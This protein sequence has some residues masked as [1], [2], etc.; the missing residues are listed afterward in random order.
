MAQQ[1]DRPQRGPAESNWAHLLICP[2]TDKYA[3][4]SASACRYTRCCLAIL[5]IRYFVWILLCQGLLYIVYTGNNGCSRYLQHRLACNRHVCQQ[6]CINMQIHR[7]Q[8]L[9]AL[10]A[11]PPR[12]RRASSLIWRS[13]AACLSRASA[14]CEL[15]ASRMAAVSGL[16]AISACSL[17]EAA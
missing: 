16:P 5:S 12:R 4:K 7:E 6:E 14:R 13:M 9:Q 10:P 15:R 2:A 17:H 8:W 3:S 1:Q 11:T